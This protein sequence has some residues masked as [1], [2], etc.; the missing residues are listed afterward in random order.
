MNNTPKPNITNVA[1]GRPLGVQNKTTAKTKEIINNILDNN[2]AT[3]NDDLSKL[4][5]YERCKILL[6]LLSYNLP[7]LRSTEL[8]NEP[9]NIFNPIVVNF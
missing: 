8:V 6:E 4:K 9:N 7:K 2:L 3:F 1:K 5:P